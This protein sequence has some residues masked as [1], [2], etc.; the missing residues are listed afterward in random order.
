MKPR[1]GVALRYIKEQMDRQIKGEVRN[2][3]V[4]RVVERAPLG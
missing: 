1:E 4:F 3:F 2:T